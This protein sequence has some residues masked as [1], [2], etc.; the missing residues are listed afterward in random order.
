MQH[1]DMHGPSLNVF[2]TID[3]LKVGKIKPIYFPEKD[4]SMSPRLLSREEA[5]TIPF[6]SKQ[7][8]NL[9]EFFS[10]SI[11]SP[12]AKAMEYT[13]GQCE[14]EPIEGE[15]KFCATTLESLLDFAG[16][17]FGLDTQFKFFSQ[18]QLHFYR[19]IHFWE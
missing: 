1:M 7:L 4:P 6:S 12:Q 8:P 17:I 14:L 2:F 15:T 19:T 13:L 16:G 10:F 3:D 11:D 18:I 5:D 9:L